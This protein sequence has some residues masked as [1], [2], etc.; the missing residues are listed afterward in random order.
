MARG[1]GRGLV[2]SGCRTRLGKR[3]PTW[4]TPALSGGAPRARW[5]WYFR[6][7]IRF[8]GQYSGAALRRPGALDKK[9]GFPMLRSRLRHLVAGAA[10]AGAL[11]MQGNATYAVA[12]DCTMAV[13]PASGAPGTQFMFSGSGYTPTELRLSQGSTMKVVP[14]DLKGAD[15]WSY[16][17]VAGDGD[18][19]R[20]K[21]VAAVDATGCQAMTVIHV[22][23]PPTS[24]STEPGDSATSPDRS[25]AIAAVSG[26]AVLFS[27]SGAFFLRRRRGTSES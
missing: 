26:L 7:I 22:A 23:L 20:W 5:Y 25:T 8:S 10:F 6:G 9:R 19:G 21:V 18:V 11:F 4:R 14:L 17:V 3:V 1:A 15:P 16:T 27:V 13:T 12:T 24:T 2:P